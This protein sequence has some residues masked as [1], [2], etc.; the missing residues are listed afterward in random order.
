CRV[1]YGRRPLGALIESRPEDRSYGLPGAR[2]LPGGLWP[3]P[4]PAALIESRPEDRSYGL[5]GAGHG[6]VGHGRWSPA[7]LIGRISPVMTG[8][9]GLKRPGAGLGPRPAGVD[10]SLPAH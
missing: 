8:K 3:L 2:S 10:G 5:P 4:S 7:A 6:R 1:A 9:G